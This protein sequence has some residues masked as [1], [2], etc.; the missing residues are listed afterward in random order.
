MAEAK[1]SLLLKPLALQVPHSHS[2]VASSPETS[3]RSLVCIGIASLQGLAPSHRPRNN[4]SAAKK[5]T[6][7]V[8]PC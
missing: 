1:I 4:I 7:S 8:S 3:P 5:L 2:G 6:L